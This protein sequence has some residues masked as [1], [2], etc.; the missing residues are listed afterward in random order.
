ME[1]YPH[2]LSFISRRVAVKGESHEI[3]NLPV[4]N[5][6]DVFMYMLGAVQDMDVKMLGLQ[7]QIKT[8]L[9]R[10]SSYTQKVADVIAIGAKLEELEH[11]N[12]TAAR[13]IAT[14]NKTALYEGLLKEVRQARPSRMQEAESRL[15]HR[16]E[17]RQESQEELLVV[18]KKYM[19][20]LMME[21]IQALE[22][23]GAVR[24]DRHR[25]AF[26]LEEEDLQA[27]LEVQVARLAGEVQQ[28]V[29]GS[30]IRVEEAFRVASETQQTLLNIVQAEGAS[31][32]REIQAY[33]HTL[34][35]ESRLVFRGLFGDLQNLA[36]YGGV[37]ILVV[38]A[39]VIVQELVAATRFIMNRLSSRQAPLRYQRALKRRFMRSRE[40]TYTYDAQDELQ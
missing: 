10:A 3:E 2:L 31:Q 7:N 5:S 23:V 32:T 11:K 26:A 28:V 15:Q 20:M 4:I 17:L 21:K 12:I 22:S 1:S 19:Q 13:I 40:F 34:F 9:E 18:Y 38:I 24:R 39:V 33:V 25:A 8:T 30:K 14:R 36:F 35:A 29:D 6:L 37:V 16:I 27:D